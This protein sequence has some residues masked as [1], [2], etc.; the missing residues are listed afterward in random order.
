MLCLGS[1]TEPLVAGVHHLQLPARLPLV[2][3]LQY[4]LSVIMTLRHEQISILRA[5][6]AYLTLASFSNQHGQYL[7]C[8]EQ[9]FPP[10]E[11]CDAPGAHF[12]SLRLLSFGCDVSST[13]ALWKLSCHVDILLCISICFKTSN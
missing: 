13:T 11:P 2:C 12:Q 6:L 7:C 1:A 9:H 3:N 8:E 5:A 10:H 4:L